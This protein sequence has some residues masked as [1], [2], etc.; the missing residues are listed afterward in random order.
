MSDPHDL[1]PHMDAALADARMI[2]MK[3]TPDEQADA[4]MEAR[5][6][7]ISVELLIA[8]AIGVLMREAELQELQ[9]RDVQRAKAKLPQIGH[10]NQ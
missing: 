8:R 9:R 6:K 10:K 2:F 7:S 5:D 4:V 3:L 1:L